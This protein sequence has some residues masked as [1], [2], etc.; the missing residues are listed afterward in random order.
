MQEMKRTIKDSVFTLMFKDPAYAIQLYRTLHPED[1]AATEADCKIVT[2]ENILT[3]RQ[4]NDL[5]LQIRDKLIVMVEAQSTYSPNIPL[6]LLMYVA[7]TYKEYANEKKLDLY[8]GK[9]ASIP[10]PELYMVYCGPK[11]SMPT[12]LHLSDLYEGQ[13]DVDLQ[14][15]VLARKND[16]SILDQYVRFCEICDKNRKEYGPT[17]EAVKEILRQCKEENI[18]VEFLA[19]REKE[20]YDIMVTLFD[21]ER[22]Q[23][24]HE[25]NVAKDARA[26]G[27]HEGRREGR[28]EGREEGRSEG[29]EDGI[30]A[31]ISTLKDLGLD[32]ELAI[33]KLVQKFQLSLPEATEKAARYWETTV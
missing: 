6:R 20:V 32:K 8:L 24:I 10:R 21:Q 28:R 23:A 5:G 22:V 25:Y 3:I 31:L 4:Y 27:H 17:V 9:K 1:T 16:G 11:R 26:E 7:E 33:Q 15:T 19:A 30:R 14:V 12:T 13:G 2:L 29:R 18:L